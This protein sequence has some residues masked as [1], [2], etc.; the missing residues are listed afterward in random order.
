MTRKRAPLIASAILSAALL[1]VAGLGVSV[2]L[3]AGRGEVSM[4]ADAQRAALHTVV[5]ALATESFL[6]SPAAA[7]AR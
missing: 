7:R 4:V 5:E 1:A 3:A 6:T 2:S